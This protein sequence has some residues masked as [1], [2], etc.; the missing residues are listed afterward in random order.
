VN[1]HNKKYLKYTN[2]HLWVIQLKIKQHREN[3][4]IIT[5]KTYIYK[6]QL[7][8]QQHINQI[9]KLKN[10]KKI[11]KTIDEQSKKLLRISNKRKI[12]R[13][14][15]SPT[16]PKEKSKNNKPYNS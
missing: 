2:N 8:N 4:Y 10:Q 1:K 13:S 12:K 11:Q 3:K 5:Y 16:I 9:N 7:T 14:K 15:A 6:F